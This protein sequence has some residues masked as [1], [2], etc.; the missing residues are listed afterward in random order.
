MERE[1]NIKKLSPDSVSSGWNGKLKN[2]ISEIL[3]VE[4]NRDRARERAILDMN[5]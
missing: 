1:S 4:E 3:D 5:A 2:Q